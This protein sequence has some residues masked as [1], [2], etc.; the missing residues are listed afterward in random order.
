[1]KFPI[2]RSHFPEMKRMLLI[3][4]VLIILIAG[5]VS[6]RFYLKTTSRMVTIRNKQEAYLYI[7]TG[8]GFDAVVDSLTSHQYLKSPENFT[9]LARRKH[10]PE[11]II[12]GRYL[13]KNG[14]RNNALVS[15]LLSGRQEP[16]RVVVHNVRTPAE[17]A[18][19]LSKKL[20]PDSVTWLK[21]FNDPDLLRSFGVAPPTLFEMFIPNTYEFYWNTTTAH[22]LE[23]IH[24]ESGAFWTNQRR[25]AAD[26]L[27]LTPGEVIALASIVDKETNKEDEMPSIAGVYLNRLKKNMLL[28]ADPTVIFAWQDFSIRRVLKKHTELRSPYNT[29]ISPGLP[30]GPICLPSIPSIEA[31]L[32]A[33]KHD[34]LYFCAK[35]DLSGYHNFAATI[36]EHQRNAKKFQKAL[37][38][39]N[40]K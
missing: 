19:K 39:L 22:F 6:L 32:H 18:G 9:W 21:S 10:L 5:V 26:S 35:D 27:H 31:V 37:N 13:L 1:M 12:P 29:Y 24:T 30:P 33:K 7:R 34:Y 38:R 23:K 2:E 15:L 36:E 25:H 8:S 40:I 16:V 11:H 3:V 28:Q 20:E 14:M 17:L 4:A